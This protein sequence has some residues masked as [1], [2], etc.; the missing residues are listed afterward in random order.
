[1]TLKAQSNL[2]ENTVSTSSGDLTGEAAVYGRILYNGTE[3]YVTGSYPIF[4]V[5][6]NADASVGTLTP[7]AVN[8]NLGEFDLVGFGL[9]TIVGESAY[10]ATNK[11]SLPATIKHLT[12][13]SGSGDDPGDDPG[14]DAYAKWLGTW[15]AG[16][17]RTLTI[18]PS[19]QGKSYLVTDS[20]FGGFEYQTWLDG[21]TG[22]ML[23]RMQMVDEYDI[24]EYYFIGVDG[25]S[26][27]Y[28]DEEND[29]LLA[30][31][32]INGSTATISPVKYMYNGN[33]VQ[34]TAVTILD[35]QTED[36]NGYDQG[37]YGLNGITD[38]TLP[39]PY[40]PFGGKDKIP[41]D[42]VTL[43]RQEGCFH[44][45]SLFFT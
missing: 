3:Y 38:L 40:H 17:G 12:Q 28:G 36:G 7:G 21:S 19:E 45:M 6:F 34:A 23:F 42:P 13:G 25:N 10:S 18:S 14:D 11:A 9:Y 33:E 2:G 41:E 20:G 37:W 35:Y 27:R 22:E 39:V 16:S 43:N 5:S 30:R 4:T 15:N 24:D 32:S 31:G 1:V 44:E 26:L 8:T 29:L